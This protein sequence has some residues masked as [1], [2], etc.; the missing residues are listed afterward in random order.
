[1]TPTSGTSISGASL[2]KLSAEA[3][4]DLSLLVATRGVVA[5][6][7]Q[8]DLSIDE[9]LAIGRHWGRLHKHATTG[10]PRREGLEEVHVVYADKGSLP[11]RTAFASS[12]LYHSD[13]TYELQPPS[14]TSL[15]LVTAPSSG[16]DTLFTS[17]A[18]VYSSFSPSFQKYLETLYAAHSGFEQA[19][20][21]RSAGQHVRREPI[22][23][24]HPVVRV[25][26]VTGVKSVFINA[27]FT[28]RIVGVPKSESDWVLRLLNE[29]FSSNPEFTARIQWNQDDVVIWDNRVVNHSATFDFW[30]ERRHAV[31]VTPH[32]ERPLSV[33]EYE[34][35]SGKPA[36]DWLVEK[37]KAL[38]VELPKLG[39]ARKD[40]G[41]KD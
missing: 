37:Y 1:M 20:G 34:R 28:R 32:G 4:D 5:F 6:R 24:I 40:R 39:H 10:V 3:L 33:E 21:A 12:E 9:Q 19:K 26:P 22:E 41:F 8:H 30:P 16:G 13:V 25:H 11:D 2:K 17:G 36:V 7:A 31:R 18:A 35:K 23:T 29:A 27:G 38:G 14:T 15:K